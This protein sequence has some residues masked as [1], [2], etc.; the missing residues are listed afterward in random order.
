MLHPELAAGGVVR[1]AVGAGLWCTG[2][3]LVR[4]TRGAVVCVTAGLA[5]L[6]AVVTG[7]LAGL[8]DGGVL[9]WVL[10]GGGDEGDECE[11]EGESD[12]SAVAVAVTVLMVGAWCPASCTPTGPHAASMSAAKPVAMAQTV[13]LL[14]FMPRTV[15]SA[16]R[17]PEQNG[18]GY[19]ACT[20]ADRRT[21]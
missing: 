5:C 17:R 2:A 20:S 19:A 16:R 18:T 11:G 13:R 7:A 3:A 12:A 8:V 10:G 15:G 14:F 4:C 9:A 1:C 21:A 6:A